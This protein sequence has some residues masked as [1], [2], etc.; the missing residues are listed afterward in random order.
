MLKSVA[1][2]GAPLPPANRNRVSDFA[3]RAERLHDG[4]I[5]LDLDKIGA[6]A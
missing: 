2:S 4:R 5:V 3:K 1:A 6:G